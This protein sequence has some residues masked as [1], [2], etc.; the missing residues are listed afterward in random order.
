M[1]ELAGPSVLAA[2]LGATRRIVDVRKTIAPRAE[3]ERAVDARGG[4]AGRLE[5]ALQTGS[6]LRV[7][8][9]CKRRSPS[10]G[11]L[12]PDYDPAVI[13]G[14]YEAAGAIAVSVLTEPT[15][16]DGAPGHLAAVRRAVSVPVL[17]KDFI[18]DPYQLLEARA[19]GAD[20]VLL[21]VTALS[22]RDLRALIAESRARGLDTLVEVHDRDELR[23][24]LDAGARIV[25]INNRN[26]RTLD[27][28]TRIAE[29]LAPEIPDGVLAVAESGLRTR[30]DV[31]RLAAAGFDGFLVGER[32]MCASDPGAALKELVACP[33]A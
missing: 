12:R 5:R 30:A 20:A 32:F 11:I 28:S 13:A 4:S 10:R 24:A 6:A 3:L 14:A 21:I 17:R 9:E 31:E 29:D 7:I 33:S 26:L 2:I 19:W 1:P 22:D 18:V 27:V 16:F 15:F 23:R 25:G 8:A